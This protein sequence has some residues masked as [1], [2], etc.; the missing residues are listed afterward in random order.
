MSL[1]NSKRFHQ[2][3]KMFIQTEQRNVM[4]KT[5]FTYREYYKLQEFCRENLLGSFLETLYCVG[6]SSPLLLTLDDI[7]FT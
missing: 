7:L 1:S 3:C 5:I 6:H 4:I 2:T